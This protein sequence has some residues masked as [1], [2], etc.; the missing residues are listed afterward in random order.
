[1]LREEWDGILYGM[2]YAIYRYGRRTIRR[3]AAHAQCVVNWTDYVQTA[4]EIESDE[5]IR[6]S[7]LAA[8]STGT[9][10]RKADAETIQ[11]TRVVAGKHLR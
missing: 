6:Q 8:R 10:H 5:S 9:V 2:E 1:V 4:Q 7:S 11:Q 3:R